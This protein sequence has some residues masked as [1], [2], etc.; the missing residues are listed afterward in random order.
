MLEDIVNLGHPVLYNTTMQKAST[1][2]T[3]LLFFKLPKVYNFIIIDIYY[4][5]RPD[6]SGLQKWATGSGSLRALVQ[7]IKIS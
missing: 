2:I 4:S 3:S 7:V 5:C 6:V 1:C